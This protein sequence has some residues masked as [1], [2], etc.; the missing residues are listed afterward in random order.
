MSY[1]ATSTTTAT[2]EF[3]GG[4]EYNLLGYNYTS[5]STLLLSLLVPS[6][7]TT[8]SILVVV[9]LVVPVVV[10]VATPSYYLSTHTHSTRYW[11]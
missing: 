4:K 9:V 5:S 7:S 1:H 10:V 2:D 8:T 11:Q 6:S 3:L